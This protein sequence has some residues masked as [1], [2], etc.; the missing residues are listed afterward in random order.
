MARGEKVFCAD[1]VATARSNPKTAIGL[2]L[3]RKS[4]DLCAL[5]FALDK[6]QG[7]PRQSPMCDCS[8]PLRNPPNAN[9]GIRV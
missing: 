7:S 8:K 1:E 2:G 3:F 6:P 9:R 4:F 5:L